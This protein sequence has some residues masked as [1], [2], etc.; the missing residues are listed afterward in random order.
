MS[1]KQRRLEREERAERR[2]AADAA[3]VYLRS[4]PAVLAAP[5][6]FETSATGMRDDVVVYFAW[7]ATRD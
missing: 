4:L 2:A 6:P 1:G 7:E 5:A 3:I